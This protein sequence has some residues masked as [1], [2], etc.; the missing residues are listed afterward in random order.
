MHV[1]RGRGGGGFGL[2]AGGGAP[3]S[4][5]FDDDT[6]PFVSAHSIP[7]NLLGERMCTVCLVR[8]H[9][10]DLFR[11]RRHTRSSGEPAARR[12]T[13]CAARHSR[14]ATRSF[15]SGLGRDSSTIEA[16]AYCRA[17]S[18]SSGARTRALGRSGAKPIEHAAVSFHASNASRTAATSGL[19]GGVGAGAEEPEL[20]VA[21]A[22]RA[23]APEATGSGGRTSSAGG[24][25]GASHPPAQGAS[26]TGLPK[27]G[28]SGIENG[29]GSAAPP[30]ASRT[31]APAL[32][33]ARRTVATR[34]REC[35]FST[36]RRTW[37]ADTGRSK[38]P[39]P[40]TK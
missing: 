7:V 16:M 6:L 26:L 19:P 2:L 40:S 5:S 23:E 34:P 20:D 3:K 31:P 12:H 24:G 38:E 4:A 15:G 35:A 29:S 32:S 37:R 33:R 13:E 14:S 11:S 9:E 30:Q 10:L 28:H 25:A 27:V 17:A 39:T 36:R 21:P 1:G 22:L 18:L 8:F